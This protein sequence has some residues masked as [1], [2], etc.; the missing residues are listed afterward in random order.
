MGPTSLKEVERTVMEMKM[1]KSL[2]P[3]G[4]TT[5]FFQKC[6]KIIGKDIWEVVEES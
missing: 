5:E 1:G 6:W 3:E 2:S 4:F